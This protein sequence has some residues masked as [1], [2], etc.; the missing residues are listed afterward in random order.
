MY[1]YLRLGFDY[2]NWYDFY[3]NNSYNYMGSCGSMYD[4]D[5]MY[6]GGSM[7]NNYNDY[8]SWYNGWYNN[9][10]NG[11]Y[12]SCYNNY[13]NYNDYNDYNRCYDFMFGGYLVFGF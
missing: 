4:N 7:Y 12:N 9:C 3:D 13:N 1:L 6:W 11:C 5:R 8:N 2:N 10:Y